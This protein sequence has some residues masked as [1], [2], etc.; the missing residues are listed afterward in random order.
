MANTVSAL[1]KDENGTITLQIQIPWKE[2]N[3]ARE[4]VLDEFAKEMAIQGFRKGKAPKNVV[5]EHVDPERLREETLKKLL[6]SFYTTAVKEHKL[7]PIVNPKIHVEKLEDGKDWTFSATTCEMPKI[8]LGDYKK[9]IQDITAKSKIVVPGKEA[10]EPNFDEMMQVILDSAE[11]TVPPM[12]AEQ[13]VDRL[14]SQTLDEIK[15]LG[16]TLEQYLASTKKTPEQL[17]EDYRV[18][19]TNDIKMEF[20]LQKIA[21]DENITVEETEID[22]AVQKA[23]NPQEKTYL[24]Q[25][26]YLLASILRQQKTLDFLKNL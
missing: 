25:N 17:R 24:E 11:L 23:P 2:V 19:A 18:K 16:L 9:K 8:R 4:S 3:L 5:M 6:P 14:L 7:T 13:E 26:R 21:E 22:E 10:K 20:V 1:I 12:L 15:K